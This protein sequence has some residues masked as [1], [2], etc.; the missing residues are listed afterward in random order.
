MLSPGRHP[1]NR[2]RPRGRS[3]RT[4]LV[5]FMSTVLVLVCGAMA[6]ATA[7]VQRDLLMDDLDERVTDAAEHSQYALDKYAGG[8]RNLGFLQIR[9]Q[10]VGTLAARLD[11]AGEVVAAA[12]ITGDGHPR[13]LSAAQCTALA[14]IPADGKPR[15]RTIPGLGDYRLTKLTDGR[16]PVLAGLPTSGVQRM[17]R[18][19]M[20]VEA[21]IALVGLTV[22][23]AVC[24]VVVRRKL[25]PLGR[26]AATAVE[27]TRVPLDRGE[28]TGLHRVSAEDTDPGTEA[29]QVGI[30]LNRLIDHVEKSLTERQ[31]TEERMRRFL[32]DA[33]H[34]LRTPLASIAGYA[35]LMAGGTKQI[36]PELAWE[37]II[38]QS[39]RMTGLVDDLFLLAHLDEG[40]PLDMAEVNIATLV[41]ESVWDARAADDDRQWRV[42]LRL[43]ASVS[44]PGDQARLQQVLAN[45]LGNARVHTPAGTNITVTAQTTP[46]DCVIRVHDD[47]PG[48]PP[49]LLSQVF[50][51]FTRAD[52]SRSRPADGNGGAGLGLAIAAAITR[53]HGGRLEARSAPGDTEFTVLLPLSPAEL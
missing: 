29:G 41:A 22:A 8:S 13:H 45:L 6:A 43:D 10:T 17:T 12:V 3:L 38:A 42:F 47:G 49:K 21:A 28:I 27:A 36:T 31:L 37:R 23:G 14:D 50:E 19:L 5:V 34:E 1:R 20:A 46:T 18:T 25:R 40:R 26:V 4:S 2:P 24:A 15:T 53:A 39:A 33:S 52:A 30:A 32:A 7:T 48:I 11:A 35:Q 44:V 51:R 9:G 16:V